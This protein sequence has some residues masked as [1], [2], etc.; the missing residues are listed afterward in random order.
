MKP[1]FFVSCLFGALV[2]LTPT[3][4]NASEQAYV[5]NEKDDDISVIDMSSLEV[6]KRF[7]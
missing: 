4:S 1:A 7:R 6:I 5:T 2:G 3:L